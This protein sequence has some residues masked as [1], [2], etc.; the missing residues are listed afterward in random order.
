MIRRDLSTH[1]Y[2]FSERYIEM[3][4][5]QL[6]AARTMLRLGVRDLAAMS[7]VT[8]STISRYENEHGGFQSRTMESVQRVLE[9]SGVEFLHGDTEH[10]PGVRFQRWRA[11]LQPF[12]FNTLGNKDWA[13]PLIYGYFSMIDDV[14][15]S[16]M[17]FFGVICRL[18]GL[19]PTLD[20]DDELLLACMNGSTRMI[21]R[22]AK[23]ETYFASHEEQDFVTWLMYERDEVDKKDG[24]KCSKI[25]AGF[26]YF[27][28]K[29]QTIERIEE[30][31]M[32][33]RQHISKFMNAKS[34]F[35]RTDWSVFTKPGS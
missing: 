10:G 20:G 15:K 3:I 14:N 31:D 11:L 2:N 5:D 25:T 30:A 23:D 17:E 4:P 28:S 33:S 1:R 6:R 9:F 22:D 18:P 34:P 13:G 19:T 16:A 21:D 29:W 32:E 12:E 24:F 26:D 35:L 27:G 7:H 8:P